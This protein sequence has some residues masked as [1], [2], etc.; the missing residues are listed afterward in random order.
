MN[1]D[2][3]CKYSNLGNSLLYDDRIAAYD[4]VKRTFF[5]ISPAIEEEY[6]VVMTVKRSNVRLNT[7]PTV[8]PNFNVYVFERLAF[9]EFITALNNLSDADQAK[10]IPSIMSLYV[11]S[12]EEI[13]ASAFETARLNGVTLYPT[14]GPSDSMNDVLPVAVEGHGYYSYEMVYSNTGGGNN[15]AAQ[16]VKDIE[17]PLTS[18]RQNDI[19]TLHVKNTGDI[20]FKYSDVV[21]N[22]S[23]YNI[24]YEISFDFISGRKI[25]YLIVNDEVFEDYKI[26]S[27]IPLTFPISYDTSIDRWDRLNCAI[28]GSFIN[29][30]FAAAAGNVGGFASSALSGIGAYTDFKFN[31]NYGSR[32]SVGGVGGSAETMAIITSYLLIKSRVQIGV[33]NFQS[34]FGKPDFAAHIIKNIK[35]GY[36]ATV[37][38]KLRENGLP[39]RIIDEAESAC[40]AGFYII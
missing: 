7:Y 21:Q 20:I 39:R 34:L 29:M 40:D 30:G 26:D 28:A 19:L 11:I 18:T 35:N 25:T 12:P 8:N 5:V 3:I 36:V 31:Q 16:I 27:N 33:N 6:Y 37:N 14:L 23:I 32:N 24:G 4:Y 13:R 22:A 17:Y 1:V 2:A 9:F 10:Y 15:W 38:C